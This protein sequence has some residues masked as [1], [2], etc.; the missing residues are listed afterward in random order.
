MDVDYF[1]ARLDA[2]PEET[3]GFESCL[4]G[5]SAT[6]APKRDRSKVEFNKG[7]QRLTEILTAAEYQALALLCGTFARAVNDGEL[8]FFSLG[9]T[10]KRRLLTHL[11]N[12]KARAP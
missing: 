7:R 10:P 9:D 4:V 3:W 11:K 8:D 6:A 5:G 1:I 2:V 12:I